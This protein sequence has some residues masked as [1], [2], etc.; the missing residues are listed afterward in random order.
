MGKIAHEIDVTMLAPHP[1]C[2]PYFRATSSLK[3]EFD[4]SHFSS[5][6][7]GLIQRH[8]PVPVVPGNGDGRY[9]YLARGHW[10]AEFQHRG[11]DKLVARICSDEETPRGVLV[12]VE[13]ADFMWPPRDVS[14]YLE[15]RNLLTTNS[16]DPNAKEL[17]V[18]HPNTLE[19]F[20]QFTGQPESTLKSYAR[21]PMVSTLESSIFKPGRG[22][23]M[24]DR[25]LN[26][27]EADNDD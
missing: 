7:L 25:I 17:F 20:S 15:L 14:A 2:L 27:V 21:H 24:I 6:S 13:L 1:D 16:A 26:E 19:K 5:L 10:V 22:P 23:L 11:I 8:K 4:W 3:K 12:E 18:Q 9:F